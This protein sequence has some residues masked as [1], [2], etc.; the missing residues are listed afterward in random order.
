MLCLMIAFRAAVIS[1]LVGTAT[2]RTGCCSS[3]GASGERY[4]LA[5]QPTRPSV[6]LI[7][8]QFP[9]TVPGDI[10]APSVS[11]PTTSCRSE[12]PARKLTLV[13]L[14]NRVPEKISRLFAG[15]T[16]SSGNSATSLIVSPRPE[17]VARE[18]TFGSINR[19]GASLPSE[20]GKA[21][22]ATALSRKA[23]EISS[24]G[25]DFWV[26]SLSTMIASMNPNIM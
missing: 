15:S 4:R 14:T 25:G 17:G 6:S 18:A 3:G 16:R 24:L 9:E 12:G 8:V 5:I 13:P 2:E 11:V 23:G 1:R 21:G 20:D 26:P 7:C 10:F 22:G 19:S